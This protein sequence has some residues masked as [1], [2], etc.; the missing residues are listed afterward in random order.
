MIEP[1]NDPYQSQMIEPENDPKPNVDIFK[2]N[3]QTLTNKSNSVNQTNKS[4]QTIL[5]GTQFWVLTSEV[6]SYRSLIII[7]LIVI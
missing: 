3:N 7:G 5:L 2:T 1:E 6:R 4:A